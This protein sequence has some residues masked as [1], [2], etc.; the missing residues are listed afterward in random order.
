M[1]IF[2]AEE[3]EKILK[4]CISP[5]GKSNNKVLLQDRKLGCEGT[6]PEYHFGG[7]N[8]PVVGSIRAKP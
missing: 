2:G 8:M 7:R 5:E 3:W 4:N 6:K 1:G